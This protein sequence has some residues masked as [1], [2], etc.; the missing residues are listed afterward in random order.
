MSFVLQKDENFCLAPV[1]QDE[2]SIVL[3]NEYR[4]HA[5]LV[6]SKILNPDLL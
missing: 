1:L 2:V 4:Q 6:S 3:V 5:K